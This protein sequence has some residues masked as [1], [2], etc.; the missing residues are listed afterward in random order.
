VRVPI[1]LLLAV[2]LAGCDV[3]WNWLNRDELRRDVVG[4]LERHG[5]APRDPA[6]SMVG[7]T[8]TGTCR[9]RLECGRI[10]GLVEGL[11]LAE[12]ARGDPAI[13]AW[14]REGGCRSIAGPTKLYRS[15]RRPA[16]LRLPSGSAFEYLLLYQIPGSDQV[17]IQVSYAYG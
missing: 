7:T 3:M 11:R 17:C 15:G 12:A 13:D 14:E 16:E 2:G 5:V 9:L 8:R 6:C 4:L 1:L 10:P